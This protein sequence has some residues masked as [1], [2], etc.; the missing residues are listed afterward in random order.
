MRTTYINNEGIKCGFI[1]SICGSGGNFL[2]VSKKKK[3]KSF[4]FFGENKKK[5]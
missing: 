5:K 1:V 2:K 4:F 3:I